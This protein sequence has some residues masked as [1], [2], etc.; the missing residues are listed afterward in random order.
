MQKISFARLIFF[1]VAGF[2]FSFH[3]VHS[4]SKVL[5]S[6]FNVKSQTEVI[7]EIIGG[8]EITYKDTFTGFD[9]NGNTVEEIKYSKDSSIKK[10]QTSEYNKDQNK[11]EEDEYDSNGNIKKKHIYTYNAN[12]DK[13]LEITYDSNGTISKKE[14]Y[15]YNDKGLKIVK[16]IYNGNDV[17]LEVH[18]FTYEM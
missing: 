4:Q 5:I 3:I 1:F 10:R 13:I 18:K 15:E 7:T 9:K 16:K 12:G 17:L 14:A 6:K 2:V 8:V 11:T